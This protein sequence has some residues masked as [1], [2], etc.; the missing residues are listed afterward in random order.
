MRSD[1]DSVATALDLIEAGYAMLAG[2]SFDTQTHPELLAVHSRLEA[3]S[4]K[5]PAITQKLIGRLAAETSPVELGGKSLADVL[6]T[7]LRISTGEARRRIK[8]SE[9][10]GQRTAMT[11]E[12][13][14]PKLPHV[15]EAQA[16]GL[17]GPEHLT[18]NTPKSRFIWPEVS[19]SPRRDS[20][21]CCTHWTAAAPFRSAPCPATDAKSTTPSWIGPTADKPTSPTNV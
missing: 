3:V 10:L 8:L 6:A 7:R 18:T 20:A 2:E 19:A 21:S 13:L 11:G 16:D 5:Q 14:A 15:A 1:C 4:W 17:L 12:P 9:S